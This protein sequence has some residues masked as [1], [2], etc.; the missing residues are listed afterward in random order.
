[1]ELVPY[2]IG[3]WKKTIKMKSRT[4]RNRHNIICITSSALMNILKPI[5]DYIIKI[6]LM[7]TIFLKS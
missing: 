5:W 1:V 4:C 2:I 3:G 7:I 6:S